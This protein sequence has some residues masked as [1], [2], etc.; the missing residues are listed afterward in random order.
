MQLEFFKLE[1]RQNGGKA[2]YE[3]FSE[4]HVQRAHSERELRFRLERVGFSDIRVF[5]GITEN[6][7]DSGSE[8]LHFVAKKQ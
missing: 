3:R 4:R 6:E 7:P 1:S 5:A 2:L 8:R